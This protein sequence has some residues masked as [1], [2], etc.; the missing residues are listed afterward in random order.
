M[1]EDFWFGFL[2][3]LVVLFVCGFVLQVATTVLS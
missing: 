2:S 3:R 1:L